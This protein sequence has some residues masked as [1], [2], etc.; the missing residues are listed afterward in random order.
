MKRYRVKLNNHPNG[1]GADMELP[2][3]AYSEFHAMQMAVE[4]WPGW[5]AMSAYS[6]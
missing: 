2:L 1:C 3:W 6:Y 5:Y 4:R